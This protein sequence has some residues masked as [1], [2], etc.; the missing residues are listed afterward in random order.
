MYLSQSQQEMFEKLKK[1]A[2]I[3]YYSRRIFN[4]SKIATIVLYALFFV[5]VVADSF[6]HFR[7]VITFI[8]AK[9]DELISVYGD[10]AFLIKFFMYTAPLWICLFSFLF[11]FLYRRFFF[12]P[13]KGDRVELAGVVLD[14]VLFGVSRAGASLG[15]GFSGPLMITMGKVFSG[16]KM[17]TRT[18]RIVRTEKFS[19]KYSDTRSESGF[20][21]FSQRGKRGECSIYRS[22]TVLVDHTREWTRRTGTKRYY[23]TWYFCELDSFACSGASLGTKRMVLDGEAFSA[24][25]PKKNFR[26][27]A[28]AAT[29]KKFTS[30]EN[31][32]ALSELSEMLDSDFHIEIIGS[33]ALLIERDRKQGS[34]LFV[35]HDDTED[36]YLEKMQAE[37]NKM[38]AI[39]SFL[40]YTG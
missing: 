18:K 1:A 7:P 34:G 13:Q 10:K 26:I 29:V 4:I 15:K 27:Q 32:R 16:R 37:V 2:R 25:D 31:L 9:T 21:T 23:E 30:E 19:S 5:V 33:K 12:M 40:V 39:L 3:D 11:T 35:E 6:T 20:I 17:T 38:K 14:R 28:D 36:S 8:D 22:D 24:G